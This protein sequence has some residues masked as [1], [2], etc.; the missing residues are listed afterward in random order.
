[1]TASAEYEDSWFIEL[2]RGTESLPTLLKKCAQYARYHQSGREQANHGVFPAVL[3]V[4]PDERRAGVLA[5]A[6]RRRFGNGTE[7]FRVTTTDCFLPAVT[8]RSCRQETTNREE[9]T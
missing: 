2:D 6:I 7:L 3:W 8:G 1:M 5:T 4:V 9:V